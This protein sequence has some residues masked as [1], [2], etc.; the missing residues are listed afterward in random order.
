[1]PRPYNPVLTKYW[2]ISLPADLAGAVELYLFDTIHKKP[3]Y[4][5]RAELIKKLLEEWVTEQKALA[6]RAQPD[7]Q[8]PDNL[9]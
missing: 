6:K 4:G 5:S 1:M 9:A 7:P 3:K 8:N 2:K